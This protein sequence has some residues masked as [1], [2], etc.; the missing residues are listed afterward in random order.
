MNRIAFCLAFAALISLAGCSGCFV[1]IPPEGQKAPGGGTVGAPQP[2]W[3]LKLDIPESINA[4]KP[5]DVA[6]RVFDAAGQPVEN[7][8]AELS[9]VMPSMDMGENK[10][11]LT[12][13]APGI[14]TGK[15]TFTMA[16]PWE[17]VARVS[18]GGQTISQ[19][20]PCN[21]R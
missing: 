6:L 2:S 15:A 1:S 19:R 11:A 21:V 18:K 10:P 16:G 8:Q 3:R 4:G 17:A 20:F 5:V 13:T 12:E 14:Y 7:A 9:L